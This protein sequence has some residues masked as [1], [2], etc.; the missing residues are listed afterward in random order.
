MAASKRKRNN[1]N[2]IDSEKLYT[3]NEAVALLKERA[4]VKFDET[5]EVAMKDRKSVV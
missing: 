1:A 3:L 5:V 4:N 2:G